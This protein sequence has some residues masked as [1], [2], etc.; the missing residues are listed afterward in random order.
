MIV[1]LASFPRCG[2]AFTRDLI[3]L[4][5]RYLTANGYDVGEDQFP[6]KL[7]VRDAPSAEAGFADGLVWNQW[8]RTYATGYPNTARRRMLR[9]P[10][11][12]ALT[13]DLRRALAAEDNLFFVK[14][15]ERPFDAYFPGEMVVQ[16]VRHPGAAIA[17]HY[18]LELDVSDRDDHVLQD[19]IRG[20]SFGG[21]WSDYHDAWRLA[22]VPR[23]L[24]RYEDMVQDQPKAVADIGAFLG[25]PA[26]AEASIKTMPMKAA[27]ERNPLRNRGAGA[28][29]WREVFNAD[30]ERLLWEIHAAAAAGFG[31]LPDEPPSAPATARS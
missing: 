23:L 5:Y 28:H 16:T 1:Y 6:P 7:E 24:L 2:H 10:A 14:T 21:R 31:Y 9:A 4:N 26:L 30:E 29:G 8:I 18:R 17:S 15:H 13:P 27:H 3:L 19:M 22:P 11:L 25:L 12:E 20:F